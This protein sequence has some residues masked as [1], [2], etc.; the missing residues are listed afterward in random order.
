MTV[1]K[2]LRN[3]SV[4]AAPGETLDLRPGDGIELLTGYSPVEDRF[5][6]DTV[7]VHLPYCTDWYSVW[8]GR[9]VIPEGTPDDDVRYIFYGRDREE[10]IDSVRRSIEIAAPLGP[11]YGVIHAGSANIGEL[12]SPVYTDRDEDVLRAFAEIL[13]QAVSGFKG[14]E[15]PFRLELENQ[16]WPGLRMLDGSN[17]RTLCNELEFENWGLCLDTGHLMVATQEAFEECQSIDLLLGIFDRYPADMI[18][19]VDVM[20][21]HCN[22]SGGYI[23]NYN[24]PDGFY[25]WGVNERISEGYGFVCGMDRHLPFS[26]KEAVRLVE[27]LNPQ[28]VTHEMGAVDPAENHTH[29]L[30]QRALFC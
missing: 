11:E 21:L 13:N 25:E 6:R 26:R 28:Y 20:H 4:Y 9:D 5:R 15:P 24:V 23:A 2:H 16:W 19:A 27:R 12:L 7:S 29:Y 14:G 17:Y 1:K 10:I 8:A 30:H 18:D 3:F 22:T